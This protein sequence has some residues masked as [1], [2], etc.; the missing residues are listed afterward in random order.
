MSPGSAH[1]T[2]RTDRVGA[3][4]PAGSKGSL[5]RGAT[6]L[7]AFTTV[8]DHLGRT[9]CSGTQGGGRPRRNN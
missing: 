2:K 5:G 6:V 3:G 8:S 7:F 4:T 1:T 9:G